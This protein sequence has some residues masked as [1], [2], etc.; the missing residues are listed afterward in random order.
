M[1][2][3]G[4]SENMGFIVISGEV[5]AGKTTLV[6]KLLDEQLYEANVA[7]V[8]HTHPKLESVIPTVL[9]AFGLAPEQQPDSEAVAYRCFVDYLLEQYR[10][11]EQTVLIIDEAQNLPLVA[12]EQLRLL[13]NVNADGHLLLQTILVGQPEL[14]DKLRLPELRQFAQRISV[15]YYLPS[16]SSEE[17][18]AYIDHRLNVAGGSPDLIEAKAK[19]AL[20]FASRGVPRLINNL[21]DLAMVYAF[22]EGKTAVDAAVVRDVIRDKKRGG[23]LPMAEASV[24]AVNAQ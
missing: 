13:S 6:R 5:G 4:L 24:D 8:S 16:L 2:E 7:L 15:D 11:G 1:L 20:A 21:A 17:A 19:A 14:R 3:Y 12:L 23:I 18:V 22:G 10:K 9:D